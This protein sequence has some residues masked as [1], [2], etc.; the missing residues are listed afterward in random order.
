MHV[1][2][3]KPVPTFGRHALRRGV[4]PLEA[5]DFAA[6]DIVES[7]HSG[8]QESLPIV[9]FDRA[10]AALHVSLTTAR[11]AA[12]TAR[13]GFVLVEQVGDQR[14]RHEGNGGAV[15]VVVRFRSDFT[16]TTGCL[17]LDLLP[18][19]FPQ[20]TVACSRDAKRPGR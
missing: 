19:A 15:N 3:L 11:Q 7:H 4:A 9:H 12:F 14:A 16:V 5:V 17:F 13:A 2:V 10:K 20:D 1:F 18:I 8:E 6:Q